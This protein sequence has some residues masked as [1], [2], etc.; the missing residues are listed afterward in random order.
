[1]ETILAQSMVSEK[2]IVRNPESLNKSYPSF[3]DDLISLGF[4]EEME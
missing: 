2:F 1:M 4:K 3:I